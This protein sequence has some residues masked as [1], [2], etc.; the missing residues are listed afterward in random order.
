MG[1]RLLVARI[2]YPEIVLTARFK[3]CIEMTAMEREDFVHVLAFERP[4]QHFATVYT[5][6]NESP[7]QVDGMVSYRRKLCKRSAEEEK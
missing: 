7:G 4:Y 1:G 5:R 3:D 2:D 6:H